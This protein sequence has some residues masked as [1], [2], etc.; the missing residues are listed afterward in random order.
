MRPRRA[1]RKHAPRPERAAAPS[2]EAHDGA[3]AGEED[4]EAGE[5]PIELSGPTAPDFS[6]AAIS[7]GKM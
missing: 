3:E 5:A 4:A 1:P 6:P 2:L 7:A